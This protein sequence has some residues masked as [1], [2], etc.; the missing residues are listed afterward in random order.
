MYVLPRT[1][2]FFIKSIDH[3][4]TTVHKFLRS[5]FLDIALDI[6][7][8]QSCVISINSRDEHLYKMNNFYAFCDSMFVICWYMTETTCYI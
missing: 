8:T 1:L 7:I 5:V 3:F 6:S 4:I 2:S